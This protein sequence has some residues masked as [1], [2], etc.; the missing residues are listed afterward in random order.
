VRRRSAT[1][2]KPTRD[3]VAGEFFGV[4]LMLV[5]QARQDGLP[6]GEIA[7]LLRVVGEACEVPE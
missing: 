5:V 6:N 1:D 4:L 3:E 2:P 7:R